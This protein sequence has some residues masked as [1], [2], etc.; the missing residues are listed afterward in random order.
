MS[1][2]TSPF[3][4]SDEQFNELLRL[5]NMYRR[6]ALMCLEA[7]A[8][9]AGAVMV[10]AALESGLMALVH[11]RGEE[12]ITWPDLPRR[13]GQIKPLREWDL[14]TLLKAAHY[15]GWLPRQISDDHEFS[16][17]RAGHGDYAKLLHLCRNLVHPNR[18]LEDFSRQRMTRKKLDFLLE[19]FGYLGEHLA[20][21]AF[22]PQELE[23]VE[24]SP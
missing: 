6:Q 17:R 10:G 3:A 9:L 11:V 20:T 19:I 24:L 7:K 15:A 21:V 13:K 12:A 16:H 14:A 23:D 4:L 1:I 2:A 8:Y 5:T 18:Y 22:R